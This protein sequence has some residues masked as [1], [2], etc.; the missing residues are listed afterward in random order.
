[1]A[2]G[3]VS[4]GVTGPNQLVNLMQGLSSIP[5]HLQQQQLII[6][7]LFKMVSAKLRDFTR[8]HFGQAGWAL[9]GG[10]ASVAPGE[11]TAQQNDPGVRYC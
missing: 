11:D 5:M 10:F 7:M 9:Q 6:F 8:S 3:V 2:S 1:M 4:G